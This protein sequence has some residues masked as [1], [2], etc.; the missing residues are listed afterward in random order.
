MPE[1]EGYITVHWIRRVCLTLKSCIY[2]LIEKYKEI[3][4][5][6]WKGSI[7]E[8]WLPSFSRYTA[9]LS[10]HVAYSS[11][12]RMVV[13]FFLETLANVCHTI[14]RYTPKYGN[15]HVFFR[16]NYFMR[17][18]DL[19]SP[20]NVTNNTYF[21]LLP[22]NVPSGLFRTCLPLWMKPNFSITKSK[23]YLPGYKD[24]QG[25]NIYNLSWETGSFHLRLLFWRWRQQLPSIR[26][27]L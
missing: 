24:F 17:L 26:R 22:S 3:N 6:A 4:R 12:L 1:E 21:F 13:T 15:Q 25:R 5:S 11:A 23:R 7:H 2:L 16:C 10:T 20:R 27:N 18:R 14:P 19:E 9:I 8:H